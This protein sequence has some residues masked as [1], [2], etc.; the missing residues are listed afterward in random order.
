MTTK[1]DVPPRA[2]ESAK[3]GPGDW[4]AKT[5][6][7]V[8]TEAKDK[9]GKN[10]AMGFKR[11]APVSSSSRIPI[12]FLSSWSSSLFF[13]HSAQGGSLKDTPWSHLTYQQYYDTSA[14]FAR[15]LLSIGFELHGTINIVG[16]NAVSSLTDRLEGWRS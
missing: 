5:L 11:V 3:G 7:Q 8:F 6:Y 12:Y 2:I 14:L 1:Q 4:P 10:N 15:A 13:L 9:W 16:F